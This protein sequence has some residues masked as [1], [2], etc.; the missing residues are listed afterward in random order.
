MDALPKTYFPDHQTQHPPLF[1]ICEEQKLISSSCSS[2]H[3]GTSLTRLF[4]YLLNL[5]KLRNKNTF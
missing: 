1:S 5:T 4:Q 2:S 3:W